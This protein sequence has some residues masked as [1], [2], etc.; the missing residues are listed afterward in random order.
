[1]K[2]VKFI[3]KSM[4]FN[5]AFFSLLSAGV[6]IGSCS[7]GNADDSKEMAEEQNEERFDERKTEKDADFL[8]E[9][10]T[11][12]MEEIKLGNLAL[13]KSTNEDV[14]E[15]ATMMVNEHTTALDD[16]KELAKSKSITLPSS[17]PEEVMD[18]YD[19][20]QEKSGKE[21]DK[22][23]CDMMVKGHKKAIDKF[24]DASSDSDDT[25][26][27][28]WA[29]SMLPALRTH[30]THANACQEKCKAMK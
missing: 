20:L 28:N 26:I 30:L 3:E 19:K 7:N 13:E 16:L 21:F 14:R 1:M 8:V 15:L 22:E 29:S 6:L 9:A 12:N 11:I 24:E 25:E 18:A 17:A 10:A 2:K 4:K 23:Y 5:M 27:R